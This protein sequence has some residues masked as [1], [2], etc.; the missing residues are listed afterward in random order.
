MWKFNVSIPD[1]ICHIRLSSTYVSFALTIKVFLRN[2]SYPTHNLVVWMDIFSSCVEMGNMTALIPKPGKLE[3]SSKWMEILLR[4]Q[5]SK[6]QSLNMVL[7][8]FLDEAMPEV[9]LTLNV[10]DISANVLLILLHP[11]QIEFY[12]ICKCILIFLLSEIILCLLWHLSFLKLQDHW[13]SDRR[14]NPQIHTV[15]QKTETNTVD[16]F[17]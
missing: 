16:I 6:T 3:K 4:D 8:K 14:H 13:K 7:F 17:R 12:V 10:S 9:E 1:V 5:E 11:C 15:V 2:H